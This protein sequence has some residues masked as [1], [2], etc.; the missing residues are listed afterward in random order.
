MLFAVPLI[1]VT[2]PGMR[3]L[4]QIWT[5]KKWKTAIHRMAPAK[6]AKAKVVEDRSGGIPSRSVC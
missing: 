4:F 2:L 3:A 5:I 6:Y 1:A